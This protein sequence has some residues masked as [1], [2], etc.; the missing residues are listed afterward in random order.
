MNDKDPPVSGDP[1]F[2]EAVVAK[3][4]GPSIIWLI[5]IVAALIGG[6]LLYKTLSEQGPSIES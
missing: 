6:W 4:R 3:S 5:P 2:A 1:Q